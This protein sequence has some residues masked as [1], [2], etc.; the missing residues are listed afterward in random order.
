MAAK[1]GTTEGA[2]TTDKATFGRIAWLGSE[3]REG[4]AAAGATVR[5]N[6]VKPF[7]LR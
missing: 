6:S 4:K 7:A 2:E 3:R 1:P 5:M